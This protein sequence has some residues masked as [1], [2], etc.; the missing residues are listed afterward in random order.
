MGWVWVAGGWVGSTR[1]E[2][3]QGRVTSLRLE[4]DGVKAVVGFR[5][6][7]IGWF[8][9][10]GWILAW[11]EALGAACRALVIFLGQRNAM[12]LGLGVGIFIVKLGIM[13]S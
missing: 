3:V 8:W 1:R 7:D 2:S 12:D 5:Y 10:R 6:F 4:S 13:G 11:S 9:Y